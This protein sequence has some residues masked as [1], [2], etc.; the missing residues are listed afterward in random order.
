MAKVF[1]PTYENVTITYHDI[2]VYSIIP[3]AY[4]LGLSN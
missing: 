1:A 4:N 2:Q 3:K